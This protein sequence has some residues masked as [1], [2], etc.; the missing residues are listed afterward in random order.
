MADVTI[1]VYTPNGS[2]VG[3]YQNPKVE[4]LPEHHYQITGD[5]YDASGQL[6]GKAEFNPQVLPYNA[7][8]SAVSKC[9]HQKLVGI[10][11]Q[12]GRQPVQMT[13]IC[14]G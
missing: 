10:Y 9:S 7:D 5:F 12:R 13:G 6:A 11:V 14:C 8:I 4:M 1:T 2:K 3:Y